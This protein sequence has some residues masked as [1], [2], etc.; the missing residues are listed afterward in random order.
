LIVCHKLLGRPFTEKKK[1]TS[2]AEL[3]DGGGGR[4]RFGFWV[5]SVEAPS[6]WR[7]WRCCPNHQ[8]PSKTVSLTAAELF[9]RE[10]WRG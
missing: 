7:V 3:D 5:E 4:R 8:D 2:W 1:K 9:L 10:R 6:C